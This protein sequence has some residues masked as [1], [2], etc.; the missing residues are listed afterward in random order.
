MGLGLV[1]QSLWWDLHSHSLQCLQSSSY[2]LGIHYPIHWDS[3]GSI[4][5]QHLPSQIHSSC[6][7][8]GMGMGLVLQD[9]WWDL[10]FHSLQYLQSSSCHLGIHYP[11]QWDS[12]GSIARQHLP[13][14]IHSSCPK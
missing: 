13:S 11:I 9:L 14:Q 5:R 4:A 7:K 3:L 12:F 10:Q 2:H 6:P 1:L 8:Q